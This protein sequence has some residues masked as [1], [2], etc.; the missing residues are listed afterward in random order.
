MPLEKQN[1]R[2]TRE[3]I[4]KERERGGK[5]ERDDR[6]DSEEKEMQ[7]STGEIPV[8][9]FWRGDDGHSQLQLAAALEVC[10]CS[11]VSRFVP[12]RHSLTMSYRSFF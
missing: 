4:H 12:Q 3:K 1:K 7:S 6:L 2:K 10:H 5:K 11:S 9:D 8:Q